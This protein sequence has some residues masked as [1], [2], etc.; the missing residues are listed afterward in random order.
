MPV[1]I[2]LGTA[3]AYARTFAPL[4]QVAGDVVVA[5]TVTPVAVAGWLLEP[6]I[7]LFA[8]LFWIPLNILNFILVGQ[9]GREV[10]LR[11]WPAVLVSLAAG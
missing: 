7:G 4:H 3:A 8:G 11:R 1:T 6:R 5:F 9:I 2:V 10:V